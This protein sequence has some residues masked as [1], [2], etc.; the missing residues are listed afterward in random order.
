MYYCHEHTSSI[1]LLEDAIFGRMDDI[2][3]MFEKSVH[4]EFI[5]NCLLKHKEN[6]FPEYSYIY[7]LVAHN[8][9][10]QSLHWSDVLSEKQ[11]KFLTNHHAFIIGWMLMTPEH[12]VDIHLIE[13]IQSRISDY[14]VEDCMIKKFENELAITEHKNQVVGCVQIKPKCVIPKQIENSTS[15][16]WIQYFKNRFHINDKES[17]RELVINMNIEKIVYWQFL[18]PK[19]PKHVSLHHSIRY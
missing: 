1:S 15:N 14:D 8:S 12:P 7:I 5:T 10:N 13:H 17:L 18:E 3:D 6:V 16:F 11:N 4:N 9:E 19:I 2:G